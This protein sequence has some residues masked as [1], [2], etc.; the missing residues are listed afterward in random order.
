MFWLHY[1]LKKLEYHKSPKHRKK[2]KLLAVSSFFDNPL[3]YKYLD[4]CLP[5]CK[6]EEKMS[7]S[8]NLNSLTQTSKELI[9]LTNFI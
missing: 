9:F 8:L 3:K 1:C 2:K 6:Y 4:N 7:K 5:M